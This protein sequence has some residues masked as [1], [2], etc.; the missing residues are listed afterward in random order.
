VTPRY[1]LGF[2]GWWVDAAKAAV[3]DARRGEAR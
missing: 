3:L 2:E 1:A